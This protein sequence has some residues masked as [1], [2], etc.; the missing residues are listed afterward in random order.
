MPRTFFPLDQKLPG[1]S[2]HDLLGCIVVDPLN[3]FH[4]YI[5]SHQSPSD[6]LHDEKVDTTLDT[7]IYTVIDNR[8]GTKLQ[9]KLEKLLNIK[10]DGESTTSR[11]ISAPFVRTTRFRRHDEVFR[12]VTAN[13]EVQAGLKEVIR[14]GKGQAYMVV[15]VKTCY[16][17][18]FVTAIEDRFAVTAE[19]T[20][21][22]KE[23]SSALS[24]LGY[25][26]KI[27]DPKISVDMWKQLWSASAAKGVGE[28]VFAVEYRL[29]KKGYFSPLDMRDMVVP[30]NGMFGDNEGG[31]IS[32][33]FVEVDGERYRLAENKLAGLP[34]Q[35]TLLFESD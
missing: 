28:Q 5:P 1:S 19:A 31:N 22:V 25:V 17:G 15:G 16:E 3:P 6:I 4:F 29:I 20:L 34:L 9:L 18:K 7:D 33:G 13:P 14:R 23:F 27:T 8:Y 12:V 24:T 21:P 35:D 30:Q 26:G 10:R 11:I 32:D 2:S